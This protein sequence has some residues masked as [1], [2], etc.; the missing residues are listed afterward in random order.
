[1]TEEE[2]AAIEQKI[3]DKELREKLK[4]EAVKEENSTSS[5]E[6]IVKNEN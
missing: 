6:N 4:E 1:M 2:R 3:R 5:N